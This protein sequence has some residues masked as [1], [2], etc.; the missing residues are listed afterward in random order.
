MTRKRPVSDEERKLFETAYREA[1]P[2]APALLKKIAPEA[3]M[4]ATPG[5]LNGRT[6]ER[7]NRGEVEPQARLDLHG[8]TERAAHGALIT[9]IRSAW[10]RGL[11]LVIVVTG[12]GAKAAAPDEPF[13]MDSRRGIL[14]S[15]TPRWLAE[16][17]L[18]G[19]VAD[20]RGAHR[21]HGGDGALYVYL[22]KN[23]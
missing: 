19:L 7:L 14:K 23:R 15:L 6:A 3:K 11:R 22:R 16:P 5:G 10:S 20:V 1:T 21:S 4:R 17:E 13:D 8:M 12:K 9:F 18:A 2:L